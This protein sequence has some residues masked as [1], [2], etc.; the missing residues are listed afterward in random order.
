MLRSD[1]HQGVGQCSNAQIQAFRDAVDVCMLLDLG[2]KGNFWTF[3]K[4]VSGGS[5]TKC[6]LDRALVNA[7]WMAVYPLASVQHLTGATCD[8]SPLLLELGDTDGEV[9]RRKPFKYE[10]MWETLD[11]LQTQFHWVGARGRLEHL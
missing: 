1:E 5:Y 3:E 2:Y 7:V 6:R 4:K 8:H 9:Q 11:G 10:L